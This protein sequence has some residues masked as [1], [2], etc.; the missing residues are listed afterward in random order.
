MFQHL[1]SIAIL[2]IGITVPIESFV[3]PNYLNTLSVSS[4]SNRTKSEPT[5]PSGRLATNTN[6]SK[7][8][9]PLPD[10]SNPLKQV[11]TVADG[12]R[13]AVRWV[14][15]QAQGS[16]TAA[17]DQSKQWVDQSSNALSQLSIQQREQAQSMAEGTRDMVRWIETQAQESASVATN[18]SKEWVDKTSTALSDLSTRQKEQAQV[19]A[20]GARDMVRWMEAQA[21]GTAVA[22]SN[23]SKEWV[24][25]FTGKKDYQ[26]GDVTKEVLRRIVSTDINISD[27]ALLLRLLLVLG[28]SFGPLA[29]ALPIT[30]LLE[31]LNVS[32]ETHVGGKI[33]GVLAVSLDERFT[34]VFSSDDDKFKLGDAVKRSAMVGIK[35]FTG[36]DSYEE[37][38]IQRAVNPTAQSNGDPPSPTKGDPTSKRL[39]IRVGPE[40]QEWDDKFRETTSSTDN[41]SNAKQ[42]EMDLAKELVEE[43][44]FR[45]K[46]CVYCGTKLPQAANFCSS[47]GNRQP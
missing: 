12:T 17:A 29:K 3:G 32:I 36:K 41:I 37:G 28:A 7:S 39:D 10:L 6:D 31:M 21:Q 22:A 14:G 25:N 24:R 46:Y 40:F 26:F 16:V 1:L 13:D 8:A 20:D 38:D 2:I 44:R 19:M 43:E 4:D 9:T 5:D 33:L 18:Q 23:Q 42:L 35:K 30:V 47:C 27:I 15:A 45:V 11:Q 34:A